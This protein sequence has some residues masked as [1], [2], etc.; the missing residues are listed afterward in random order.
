MDQAKLHDLFVSDSRVAPS[1]L[2]RGRFFRQ[3]DFVK[4]YLVP[5]LW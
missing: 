5:Y 3:V 2:E 1:W 4:D